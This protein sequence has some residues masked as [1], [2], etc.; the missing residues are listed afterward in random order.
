MTR[1]ARCVEVCVDSWCLHDIYSRSATA[2]FDATSRARHVLVCAV[3][4]CVDVCVCLTSHRQG[5]AGADCDA[6]IVVLRK[7]VAYSLRVGDVVR[8]VHHVCA[9]VR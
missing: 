3:R 4:C 2:R 9:C 6:R 8:V 1:G 5:E 7:G